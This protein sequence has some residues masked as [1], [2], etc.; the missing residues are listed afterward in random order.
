[1]DQNVIIIKKDNVKKD[2]K[3]KEL[4]KKLNEKTINLETFLHAMAPLMGAQ[5]K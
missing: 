3:I 5:K 2:N 1:M 4:T